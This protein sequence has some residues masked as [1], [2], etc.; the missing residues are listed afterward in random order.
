MIYRSGGPASSTDR[1]QAASG[2][3]ERIGE[4]RNNR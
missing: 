1:Q 4:E 2:A 3:L